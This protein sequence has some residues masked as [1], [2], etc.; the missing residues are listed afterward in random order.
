M[1]AL[2]TASARNHPHDQVPSEK[3][4]SLS[5]RCMGVIAGHA[6]NTGICVVRYDCPRDDFSMAGLAIERVYL[7]WWH[8]EA[9]G[10]TESPPA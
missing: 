4:V 1:T 3:C 7:W 9:R 2:Y 6:V 5:A 8:G 10:G